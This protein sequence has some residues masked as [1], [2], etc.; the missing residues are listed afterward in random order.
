AARCALL[1]L[2]RLATPAD[3]LSLHYALPIFLGEAL[4]STVLAE[5]EPLLA[6]AERGDLAHFADGALP[7]DAGRG[8]RLRGTV[9]EGAA[10]AVRSE[11]HT[12]EL[13]SLA[14][15]VCRLLLDKKKPAP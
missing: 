2:T 15:L 14:Y 12:S 7:V 4:L 3:P 5:V 13:Q 1:H 9:D 11:E 10:V 8:V 6:A